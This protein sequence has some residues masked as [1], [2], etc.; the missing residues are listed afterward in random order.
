MSRAGPCVDEGQRGATL[1]GFTTN[2][3]FVLRN[4]A[5]NAHQ[6][7]CHRHGTAPPK[8]AADFSPIIAKF[9]SL[10]QQIRSDYIEQLSHWSEAWLQ[11]WPAKKQEG[12]IESRTLDQVLPD[13]V[14]VMVK[15]EVGHSLPTKARLI[16]FYP[17]FATQSAF[18]PEFYALQKTYTKLLYRY[19]LQPGVRVTF[20]S[21]LNSTTLGTW[22]EE[23]LDSYPNPKFYE[24]DGKNWD[25]TMQRPHLDVRLAAYRVAGEDF[26]KFVEAGYKVTGTCQG[27]A[28]KYVL[29]GTVKSGHNDTTMGNSLVNGSIA[30][31]AMRKCGLRGDVIVAGDDLLAVIDG[32]FD[33]DELANVER[34]FGIVPEYRKFDRFEDT[35]FISGIWLPCAHG[36]MFVPK[37]GRLLA[38]LFWTTKPP[39]PKRVREYR[40]G[41]VAGL[42]PTCGAMPIIGEF[43]ESHYDDGFEEDAVAAWQHRTE[44]AVDKEVVRGDSKLMDAFCAR[45][46]LTRSDV[47]EVESLLRELPKEATGFLSHPILARIVAHDVADVHER[48]TVDG[49]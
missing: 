1:M 29:E 43:L 20:A 38:R 28:L 3:A 32:D 5:C 49:Q 16:Q 42:R 8:F 44:L 40:N 11:K 18:G 13:R 4:C 41:V 37:P 22:M 26:A 7:L 46:G 34:D 47:Q 33:A 35:T 2:M 48:P 14:K 9:D 31:L 27:N 15:R 45:Y 17:N 36:L 19:E 12:I 39:P 21:G 25:S 30:A 23:V 10:Y 24:R 6:A